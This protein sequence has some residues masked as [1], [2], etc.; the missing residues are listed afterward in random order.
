MNHAIRVHEHGGPEKLVWEEVPLP[1]PKPGEVLVRHHAVGLNY[2]ELAHDC[3]PTQPCP[4]CTQQLAGTPWAQAQ[5]G[6]RALVGTLAGTS[7]K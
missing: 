3:D 2:I 1:D 7:S 6:L 5:V 4:S